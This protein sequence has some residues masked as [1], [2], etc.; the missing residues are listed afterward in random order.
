MLLRGGDV[1][2]WGAGNPFAE[3]PV[4]VGATEHGSIDDVWT[5][6][7]VCGVADAAGCAMGHAILAVAER[8]GVV[9]LCG[10]RDSDALGQGNNEDVLTL[11]PMTGRALA[12]ST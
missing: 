8:S 4:A 6:R 11:I 9:K 1:M 10:R 2:T 12:A 7:R 3:D 5:P